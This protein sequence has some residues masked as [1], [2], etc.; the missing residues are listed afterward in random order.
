MFN[1]HGYPYT[2]FH[3]LNLDWIIEKVAQ[4]RDSILA[5]ENAFNNLNPDSH[6][7]NPG[8]LHVGRETGMYST[9][10]SA[11][12]YAKTYCTPEKRVL[13]IIH[14]GVYNESLRLTPNP[15]IDIIG[16]S[17][18]VISCPDAIQYP[19]CAL[20][21]NGN[22]FFFGIT[23]K[24]SGGGAYALH[25]EVQGYEDLTRGSECVFENC[26]FI[27]MN[28]K[29]G[30]GCGGG[31]DDRL[32]FINCTM[33][34]DTG[35][36]VYAHNYPTTNTQKFTFGLENCLV[37]GNHSISLD[38]YPDNPMQI[39]FKN[40]N[41]AGTTLV[42]N[43]KDNTSTGYITAF[44]NLQNNSFGNT[45]RAFETANEIPVAFPC[46]NLAGYM[47]AYIPV[48]GLINLNSIRIVAIEGQQFPT[49]LVYAIKS[50]F[51]EIAF[52]A[53]SNPGITTLIGTLEIRP[54]L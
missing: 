49:E 31:V 10:N 47:R 43:K 3:E 42:R 32:L 16:L 52:N 50:S 39:D 34:S 46:E 4:N 17:E 53:G 30:I 15:G 28:N 12:N 1:W 44:P 33:S 8:V 20:Y 18:T 26:H 40:N 45:G 29:D 24:T 35:T 2:N 13:I 25:Y 11:I 5:L 48:A 51:V 36:A 38:V 6:I 23:F 21:T 27:G 41:L 19:D 9:I 37:K 54:Q 14:G 7:G 22:G